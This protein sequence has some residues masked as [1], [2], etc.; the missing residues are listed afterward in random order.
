[1]HLPLEWACNP[2]RDRPG[3]AAVAAV[4]GVVACVAVVRLGE[5]PLLEGALCL[6][7]LGSLGPLLAPAR[8]RLDE[9][10]VTLRGPFGD[11]RRSWQTL[12]RA[13]ERPAGLLVSPYA[14]PHWLDPYRGL[15]LP[16][17]SRRPEREAL[18]VRL[19]EQLHRH[20][21]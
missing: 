16:L 17:P 7:V 14:R 15:L 8:C 6:A 3:A 20:G 21:L 11:N 10:G 12:R 2:W 13:S 1:M 4:L 9:D 19:R 5:A 18:L